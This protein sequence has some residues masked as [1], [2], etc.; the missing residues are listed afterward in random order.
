MI[1]LK[2]LFTI[3]FA[4]SSFVL[5]VQ[6]NETGD[7]APTETIYIKAI[8]ES[9]EKHVK[10]EVFESSDCSGESNTPTYAK[11]GNMVFGQDDCTSANSKFS[12]LSNE[13]V[14]YNV[15]EEGGTGCSGSPIS[16]KT[17]TNTCTRVA[18]DDR[19]LLPADGQSF[20]W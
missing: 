16:S 19:L 7:A 18:E 10:I 5:L 9:W 3:I 13:N 17:L 1:Y 20:K 8:C 15:Y 12:C 4:L 2:Y 11:I 6:C 14:Q